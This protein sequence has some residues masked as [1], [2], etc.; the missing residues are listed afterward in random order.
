M[1][2]TVT[3]MW[4]QFQD[5]INGLSKQSDDPWYK[6]LAGVGP[7]G[8]LQKGIWDLCDG[9]TLKRLNDLAERT[10]DEW[11]ENPSILFGRVAME[12]LWQA[13]MLR[14]GKAVGVKLGGQKLPTKT[15]PAIEL[16]PDRANPPPKVQVDPGRTNVRMPDKPEIP[17]P[18][19]PAPMPAPAPGPKP[20]PDLPALSG[21]RSGSGVK[22]LT[23]PPNSAIKGSAG[24]VYVTD[25]KGNVILDITKDRVK[26]VIPGVG[27]GPKRLPTTAE[28]EL[29]KELHGAS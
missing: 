22:H 12:A 15:K 1:D 14:G 6:R 25:G 11:K 10:K 24:R 13:L 9:T 7:T 27:F 4:R 8:P 17:G 23:G 20:R 21:G 26:P 2:G 19:A 3:G 28:L 16:P 29:I 5:N 18:P